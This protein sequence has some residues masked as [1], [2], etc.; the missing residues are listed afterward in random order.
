MVLVACSH[1]VTSRCC[2][3]RRLIGVGRTP[4]LRWVLYLTIALGLV[5]FA[6]GWLTLALA[7]AG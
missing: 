2:C 6:N 7:R 3:A 4:G 5:I 1:L